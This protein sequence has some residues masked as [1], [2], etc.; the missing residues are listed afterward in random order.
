[1]AERYYPVGIQTFRKIIKEGYLY[2]DKTDLIWH[3][4]NKRSYVFL[5]R[6]RR[7]GKSLLSSTLHSFFAGEKELF[8]GLKIMDLEQEWK[9]YPVIHLDL[10]FAK[11]Q[12]SAN[13]LRRTLMLLLSRQDGRRV[14]KV[15]VKFDANTRTPEEWFFQDA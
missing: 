7:F 2:I 14:I 11:G 1:M 3:M 15:G 9:Q 13:E 10:S 4:Q 6:P 8:R 5:S 12:E